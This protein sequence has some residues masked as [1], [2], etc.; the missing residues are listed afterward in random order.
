MKK[1]IR[2]GLEISPQIR[3]LYPNARIKKVWNEL[4]IDGIALSIWSEN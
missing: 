2:G 4:R 1:E 3:N